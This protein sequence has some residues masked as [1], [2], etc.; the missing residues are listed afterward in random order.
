MRLPRVR[1]PRAKT[2]A[3]KHIGSAAQSMHEL[4]SWGRFHR[5]QC[6]SFLVFIPVSH[7]G[8]YNDE[9]L[10]QLLPEALPESRY[11]VVGARSRGSRVCTGLVREVD[12][13]LRN[14]LPRDAPLPLDRA[15]ESLKRARIEKEQVIIYWN[16]HSRGARRLTGVFTV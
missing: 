10:Q 6:K 11:F 12:P 15:E 3:P 13:L 5:T 1:L 2:Y 7:L 14:L 4:H 8:I 9:L 16:D